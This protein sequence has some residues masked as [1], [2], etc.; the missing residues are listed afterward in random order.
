[1]CSCTLA[2]HPGS[3]PILNRRFPFAFDLWLYYHFELLGLE[4]M[5][6]HD[7]GSSVRPALQRYIDDGRVS[8]ISDFGRRV[9]PTMENLTRERGLGMASLEQL[10]FDRCLAHARGRF[11]WVMVHGL[12]EFFVPPTPGEKFNDGL[13]QRLSEAK[14]N[15]FLIQRYAVGPCPDG[16][17][18]PTPDLLLARHRCTSAQNAGVFPI[19]DPFRADYLDSHDAVPRYH[20]VRSVEW[21]WNVPVDPFRDGRLH[22]YVD[23]IGDRCETCTDPIPRGEGL[24]WAV[25]HLAERL[26]FLTETHGSGGLISDGAGAPGRAPDGGEAAQDCREMPTL[27]H[28]RGQPQ[29]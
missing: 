13:L 25:P 1:L 18:S 9:S 15:S 28:C 29:L 21:P 26:A 7:L 4:H 6:V 24:D 2:I 5:F 19:A 12:D 11:R 16:E 3:Y 8:Y 17:S 27:A 14:A 22:H 20:D 10:A 23:S